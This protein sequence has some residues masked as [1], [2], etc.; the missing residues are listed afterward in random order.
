MPCRGRDLCRATRGGRSPIA[1]RCGTFVFRICHLEKDG[2]AGAPEPKQ[3]ETR[4][5]I[6]PRYQERKAGLDSVCLAEPAEDIIQRKHN[7]QNDEPED[8]AKGEHDHRLKGIDY[9]LN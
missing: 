3:I 8:P 6:A 4:E 7:R 5:G 9:H 2:N 1:Q